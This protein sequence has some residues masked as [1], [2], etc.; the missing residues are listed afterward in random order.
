VKNEEELRHIGNMYELVYSK[1]HLLK[2]G[3]IPPAEIGGTPILNTN[4]QY[5]MTTQLFVQYSTSHIET[6]T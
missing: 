1:A 4:F 2:V 6:K 3:A 5:E